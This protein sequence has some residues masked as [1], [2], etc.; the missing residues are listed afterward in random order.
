MEPVLPTLPCVL[1]FDVYTAAWLAF[2]AA[3]YPEAQPS[4]YVVGYIS[5][6][7]FADR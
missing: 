5:Q 1:V 3:V 7:P 2:Q 6:H 4:Q